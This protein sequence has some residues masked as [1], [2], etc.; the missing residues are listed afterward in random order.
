M[1]EIKTILFD[2]EKLKKAINEN[3][4]TQRSLSRKMGYEDSYL[5]STIKR[6]CK[7]RI[8]DYKLMCLCLG[9]SEDKLIP[10]K[11]NREDD[12]II[13]YLD[14]Y[15]KRMN[16]SFSTFVKLIDYKI[17]NIQKCV[18]N[19]DKD[20]KAIR[21][22]GNTIKIQNEKLKDKVDGFR[23]DLND[24]LQDIF[25]KLNIIIDASGS[26]KIRIAKDFLRN[27]L[28]AEE[29]D[30]YLEAQKSQISKKYIDRAKQELG[31]FVETKGYGNN[32]TKKWHFSQ[33]GRTWQ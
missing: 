25:E 26:D 32:K 20:I 5:A 21:Q 9:I 29:N 6:G 11:N 1:Q 30:I 28:P 7:I 12:S 23:L 13:Q 10:D 27:M 16:E 31:V 22:N 33:E 2:K 14:E 15:D 18:E 8:Q 24:E 3:G 19:L 17:S 4:Y